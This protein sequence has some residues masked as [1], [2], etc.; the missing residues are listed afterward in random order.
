MFVQLCCFELALLQFAKVDL[1]FIFICLSDHSSCLPTEFFCHK[2]AGEKCIAGLKQCDGV[3]D[4]RG[5]EDEDN[6][7][8]YLKLSL[9]G[10][11]P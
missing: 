1:L 4:C 8:E 3:R 6:C 5:G 7:R 11:S 10:N 9:S 2:S